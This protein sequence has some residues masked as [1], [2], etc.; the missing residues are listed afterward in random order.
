MQII[1]SAVS[2]V[3]LKKLWNPWLPGHCINLK[4]F[5]I[6]VAIINICTD[7]AMLLMPCPYVWQLHMNKE[8]KIAVVGTF[9][10]G[11]LSVFQLPPSKHPF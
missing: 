8:R 1:L 4:N 2:C 6:G 9:L 7:T 5:Y 10:V 11:G 3:P